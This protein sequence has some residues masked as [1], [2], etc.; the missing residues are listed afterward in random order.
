MTSQSP[1]NGVMT[2]WHLIPDSTPKSP[3]L[4]V[5]SV[6]GMPQTP[7]GSQLG[8]NDSK[9]LTV[10]WIFH[11]S[12]ESLLRGSQLQRVFHH[13][14]PCGLPPPLRRFYET[15]P[16]PPTTR[17]FSPGW[18]GC[19]RHGSRSRCSPHP[20]LCLVIQCSHRGS[21]KSGRLASLRPSSLPLCLLERMEEILQA[22][23]GE[24]EKKKEG[25]CKA[26]RATFWWH[27]E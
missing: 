10:G 23:G 12:P 15:V 4:S 13:S 8:M 11:G 27:K 18:C 19:R 21:W 2:S 1:H 9:S 24:E 14:S 22:E 16:G 17:G 3:T 7:G 26:K 20:R 6:C 25:R 5:D